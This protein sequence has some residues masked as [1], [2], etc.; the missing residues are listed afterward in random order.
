M[1]TI[2]IFHCNANNH[3]MTKNTE[4]QATSSKRTNLYKDGKGIKNR[5]VPML[6]RTREDSPSEAIAGAAAAAADRRYSMERGVEEDVGALLTLVFTR[7]SHSNFRKY[8]Y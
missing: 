7:G 1:G 8:G 5:Q 4:K 6:R 3:R 2:Q